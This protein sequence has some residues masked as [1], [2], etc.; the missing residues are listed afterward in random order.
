M[1]LKRFLRLLVGLALLPAAWGC[2]VALADAVRAMPVPEDSIFPV[3]VLALLAGV[4]VYLAMWI[5]FPKPVRM[6]VLGHELTHAV[7]AL[8][9]GARVS[10]LRVRDNGG[11][12]KLSK[13]NILITLAPYFFPFYTMIVVL[14]AVVTRLWVGRLPCPWAWMFLVGFTWCFHCCFTVQSL[15]QHQPDILEYGRV[16]SWALIFI[17]NA[18]GIL[19]WITVT[20]PLPARDAASSLVRRVS[21]AY[22]GVYGAARS[23]VAWIADSMRSGG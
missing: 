12:V 3:G 17:F 14:V 4:V 23:G 9:F 20:A 6:Y 10:D 15:M 1:R 11:S 21:S 16:F 13:S 18:V 19:V 22:C 2:A 5:A 8:M 7:W